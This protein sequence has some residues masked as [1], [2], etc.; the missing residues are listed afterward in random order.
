[1]RTLT[2]SKTLAKFEELSDAQQRKVIEENYDM[3]VSDSFWHECVTDDAIEIA[4]LLGIDISNVYFSGFSSQGDGACFEGSFR[5]VKGSVAKVKAF[6]PQDTE[7][8]AIAKTLQDLHR[9]AFYSV[10]GTV[11]QYGH[12]VHK[13]SMRIDIASDYGSCDESDW[14]EAF[15]DFAL[16][17]YRRLEKEYEYQTS[18]EVIRESITA[19]EMEFE[20]ETDD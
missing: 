18:E 1:M 19:N 13:R 8:H 15:A 3:N 10:T 12:Y 16:W 2:I 17:I 14:L 7:L 11:R 9:R 20:V 4:A 5:H 6:A